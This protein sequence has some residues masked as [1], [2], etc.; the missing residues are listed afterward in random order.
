VPIRSCL[1]SYSFVRAC[2]CTRLRPFVG[3]RVR[4][5]SY[6]PVFALIRSAWIRLHPRPPRLSSFVFV[7]A[8]PCLLVLVSTRSCSL[9]LILARPRSFSLSPLVPLVRARLHLCLFVSACVCTR[10]YVPAL[11]HVRIRTRLY[12][13]AFVRVRM[14][15]HLSFVHSCACLFALSPGRTLICLC[16]YRP[17]R[18]CN[19]HL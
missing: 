15:L 1:H 8:C 17:A 11:M 7:H 10:L 2:V 9:L 3:A 6:T 19:Y 18:A 5:R 16:L 13:L 14:C 12:T 4:A